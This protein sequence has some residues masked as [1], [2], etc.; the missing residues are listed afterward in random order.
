MNSVVKRI[1]NAVLKL[2]V[3]YK[4]NSVSH[5]VWILKS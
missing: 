5:V 2:Y 4:I 3:S 1:E